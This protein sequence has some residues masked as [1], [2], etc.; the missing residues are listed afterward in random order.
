[1]S[2]IWLV[3]FRIS[4]QKIALCCAIR[5]AAKLTPKTMPKYFAL[6]PISIF[7]ATQFMT[8]LR[9]AEELNGHK[10]A[11][12]AQKEDKNRNDLNSINAFLL[13]SSFVPFVP[14][15]GYSSFLCD[16]PSFRFQSVRRG[17]ALR[18]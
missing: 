3:V 11:Q 13:W 18:A 9:K 8:L 16:S 1:M 14:F 7:S 12:E 17:P 15:C 10:K 4:P 2:R 5:S 6:S